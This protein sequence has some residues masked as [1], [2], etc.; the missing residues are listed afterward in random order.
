MAQSSPYHHGDLHAALL[1]GADEL[2]RADGINGLS[3]RKLALATGVSRTAPY[4]HFRD[5]HALLCSLAE[6]GFK[7]LAELVEACRQQ[8]QGDPKQALTALVER[9]LEFATS[10]P[11]RYEL[12]FGRTIWQQGQ[13]TEL[14]KTVAYDSFQQYLSFIDELLGARLDEKT[15]VLRVA[16]ATWGSLHG[17]CRLHI[18]GVYGDSTDRKGVSEVLVKIMLGECLG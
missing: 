8:G 6:R 3:L 4:H 5:K 17:L 2:L 12:M 15:P 18:D 9:Y 13:P 1:D 11:E 7:A 14:L 16:Q 10:H